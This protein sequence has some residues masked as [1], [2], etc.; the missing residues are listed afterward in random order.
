VHN[1]E[2]NY[3]VADDIS[4]Y[5]TKSHID[6]SFGDVDYALDNI[7]DDI[8]NLDTNKAD[9]TEVYTRNLIDASIN[10]INTRIADVSSY[11]QDVSTRMPIFEYNS[12]TQTLNIIA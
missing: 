5:Y 4:I 7:S 11:A 8:E 9:K 6:A 10:S 1:I 3:L 12:A 2:S